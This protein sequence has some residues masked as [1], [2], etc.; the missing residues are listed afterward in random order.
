[1][2]L[3][4]YKAKDKSGTTVG[5]SM[6]AQDSNAVAGRLVDLG[7]IPISI[8]EKSSAASLKLDNYLLK[9]Q[10][11]KTEDLLVF[12][13]QL[14]SIL[15]AGVP[16]LE[17]L[18]ALHE[19]MVAPYLKTVIASI[20]RDIQGGTSFSEALSKFPKVF[21]LP[22][23]AM[24][25]VGEKAGILGD[26]LDRLA[27]LLERDYD[28]VQKIKSATRYPTL[29]A[30]TLIVA[31]LFVITFVVPK[32][33]SVFASSGAELPMPTR[34]LIGTNYV[35][36]QYFYIVIPVLFAL[37][38]LFKMLISTP[39]GKL[40]WDGVLLK[41]PVFGQLNRKLTLSR[42]TRMLS[43]MLKAGVPILDALLIIK[44][45]IDNRVVS[46]IIGYMREEVAKGRTL[47]DPMREHNKI[48]PPLAI[49]M[50]SIGEK[51]GNLEGMLSKVADYFD[52][53]ADYM[54]KNLT[55]LIEPL[56][57][58]VLAVFVTILAL[59]IFLPMWDLIKV[60]QQ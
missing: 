54:I 16:L 38:Y 18:D 56:M 20:K 43:S 17:S 58:A 31:F 36:R 30:V 55:P 47:A 53:D 57:I 7:F 8:S 49:Q 26:V 21:S 52:R 46:D 3:Y 27:G 50:V 22:F 15:E 40:W 24:I 11:V 1:M 23:V 60:Y 13:R 9:F 42:F 29:V 41:L 33:S 48:I 2:P 19:Q 14:S 39:S 44:D 45:T 28:N 25:R 59:G 35:I 12:V 34:I 51:S 37:V 4:S 5:G 10:K 6:E 32:F